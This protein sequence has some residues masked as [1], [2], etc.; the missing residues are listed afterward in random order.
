M[1]VNI[2]NIVDRVF[3]GCFLTRNEVIRLLETPSHSMDAGLIMAAANAITRATSKG[4]AEVHAQIG[5]NLSPCPNNCSFCAFSAQN[6]VFTQRKE[7]GVEEIVQ[8]ALKAE[9]DEPMP[10]FL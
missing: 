8:L 3:D 7:L 1:N 2:Q 10:C 9:V 4:K 5:L 6:K